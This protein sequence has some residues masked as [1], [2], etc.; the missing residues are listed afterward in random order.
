MSI[1]FQEAIAFYRQKL[2]LPTEVWEQVIE[3][4]QDWAFTLAGVEKAS[5]LQ[6]VFDLIAKVI[7]GRSTTVTTFEDFAE[8]FNAEMVA[9]GY[10]EVKPWR[11]QLVFKQNIKT[12]YNA[13]RYRTQ[14]DPEQIKRRP[15]LQYIHDHPI[16]PRPHHKALHNKIWLK[17]DPIWNKIAPLNGFGCNCQTQDLS[18]RDMKREGLKVSEPIT[19]TVILSDRLT[20][21]VQIVPAITIGK[22]QFPNQNYPAGAIVDGDKVTVAIADF[23]FNFAPGKSQ[24][25]EREEILGRAIARLSPRLQQL[26]NDGN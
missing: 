9:G 8:N 16:V 21:E 19:E 26:V 5:V 3:D 7:E 10:G 13:G 20:G 2:P 6:S 25:E 15:Y 24:P 14:F 4:S 12:A 23:G 11:T 22:S 1:L 18:D 17:S